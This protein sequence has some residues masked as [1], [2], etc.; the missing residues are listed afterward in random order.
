M[1]VAPKFDLEF[2]EDILASSLRDTAYLSQASRLLESHHFCT[3]NHAWIWTTIKGVWDRYKEPTRPK[4]MAS[5]AKSDLRRDE[6]REA[7]LEL[8]SK[9][10]R[11]KASSPKAALEVLERFT[12]KT[13]LHVAMEEAAGLLEFDDVESIDKMYDI[14]GSAVRKTPQLKKY[15]AT[16]WIEEFEQRQADR[17]HRKEHPE[18]YKRIA[19]GFKRIDKILGGGIEIGELGNMMAVT[20]KGKSI[21]L[22]NLAFNAVKRGHKAAIIGMEMPARQINQRMDSRWLRMPYLKFKTFEFTSAEL[23]AIQMRLKRARKRFK[24]R[25]RV[26]STPIRSVDVNGLCDILSDLKEDG[27][28]PKALFLDSA[29][30]M[31]GPKGRRYE[32]LRVEQTEIYWSVKAL[33]EDE[34]YAIWNSLHAGRE[35]AEKLATAEASSES[36]DKSRIADIVISLN[37]PKRKSRSTREIKGDPDDDSAEKIAEREAKITGQLVEAFIAKYRDGESGITVPMDV[38]FTRM[39]MDEADVPE[40]EEAEEME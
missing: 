30:H 9:L 15:T 22:I 35:W 18:E 19:T 39:H 40:P 37:Q 11:R 7:V 27:F 3:K 17:Q 21:A 28:V 33:A 29:D 38:N 16:K 26:I 12:K 36:Y 25:L 24:G 34:G 6:D 31:L 4:L 14:V 32:S 20:G 5:R 23:R 13:N 2:E 10:Y 1:V 8:A